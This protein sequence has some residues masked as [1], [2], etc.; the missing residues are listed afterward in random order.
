[1][2]FAN[3]R[4]ALLSGRFSLRLAFFSFVCLTVLAASSPR[5]GV[6]AAAA[7]PA[8][9]RAVQQKRANGKTN[10][11]RV[12]ESSQQQ[13]A[14]SSAKGGVKS[15]ASTDV[16]PSVV[17][18]QNQPITFG[19]TVNGTL[20]TGDC[21]NPVRNSSGNLDGTLVDEYTFNG[22]AGQQVAIEMTATGTTE[23]TTLDTYLYLLR[24]DGTVL[25]Q[26]DDVNN[27]GN[28]NSRIP[29]TGFIILPASGTYSIL[30]NTF[31]PEE[32]GPY[33]LTLTAGANC[34]LSPINFGTPQTGTLANTDCRSPIPLDDGAADDTPVDFY[35]FNGTAGQQISITL[36]GTSGN[37]NPYLYLLLPNGD[38]LADDNNGG[39]GS[40]ARLPQ[41]GGFG[42]LPVTGTY[43]IIVNTFLQGQTGNYSIALNQSGT[44]PS[45][46]LTVGQSLSGS[47][48][49]GDCRLLEDG[50][51]LDAYTFN[52]TA[53]Q[54]VV[55][56]MT[57]SASA[58]VPV[59]FLLAPDGSTL[60]IDRNANGANLARIPS[61]GTG[62]FSLPLAGN[63]TVLA[64]SVTDGQSGAYTL[65]LTS[66]SALT[67]T[68]QFSAPT[69]TVNENDPARVATI[70]VT[71]S[72][73]DAAS[74]VSVEYA[75]V[76]DPAAVPCDPTIR[77][78][79]GALFPQGR[80]YAR[81]DYS[82]SID[83]L[84]FA[85]GDTRPKTFT[86][87]LINDVHVEGNETFQLR[88][89]NPQGALLGA[90]ATATVTLADDD[91][92]LSTTNPINQTPFFVRQ[93]YLDFLSREPEA[94]EPWSGVLGRCADVFNL[95]PNSPSAECDRILV[96]Q[97]F[98]GSPE[99]RLKGFF[100]FLYYK[101]SF[102]SPGNPNYVPLY[103]Q[104][105]LDSR[106]VTGQTAEE[107]IA[108]RTQFSTGWLSRPE[109]A[110][111]YASTANAEF[112]DR[113]LANL[114]ASLTDPAGGETRTSL[115]N[116]LNAGT[117][118]RAE[119]LRLIVESNEATAIQFNRAFVAIQYYGYLRR[120]P[121]PTG[122]QGWLDVIN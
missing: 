15:S 43:T 60:D 96:S 56:S 64:N 65:S 38:V 88:L 105:V 36:T 34:N 62:T 32:R 100:V 31:R 74:A 20:A 113:L 69:F 37:I 28:T 21:Q 47:L 58:L 45:A 73:G 77:Q 117:R 122:Y 80:A 81:C 29:L 24:P 93:Q 40:N 19:Q 92:A 75:T 4:S 121:E 85:A 59:L 91:T 95:N 6:A 1:M 11:S 25:A 82:T 71:R 46:A 67:G 61:S 109:F 30:A 39:G 78:A 119:V 98:F 17:C 10:S 52:G 120:T 5:F 102:G 3:I 54:Q 118:T 68:L 23:Q 41:G 101:A 89:R 87:P 9:R 51:L 55:L 72:G 110:N 66:S 53:G 50:S 22:T 99:F 48:A 111:L 63:Y 83:T 108:K 114:G 86:I 33:R 35:I 27:T 115:V 94:A 76:D 13:S 2:K 18:P 104:F 16:D 106:R 12:K 79:D 70:T 7:A 112:V 116:A 97:S 26:N 8:A 14:T 44:C 42:R 57:S 49:D 107:V 84:T 90:Q 103:D